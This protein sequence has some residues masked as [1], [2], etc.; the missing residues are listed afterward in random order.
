MN[1]LDP[2]PDERSLFTAMREQ[3]QATPMPAGARRGLATRRLAA[4]PRVALGGIA[5]TACG[6]VA[7]AAGLGAFAGTAPA[8]AVTDNPDGSVTITLND[9]NA[10]GAL[11]AKLAAESVAVRAVPVE[12]GCT[13]RASVVKNGVAGAPQILDAHPLVLLGATPPTGSGGGLISLTVDPPTAPGR[14]LLVA[15][16]GSGRMVYSEEIQGPVPACVGEAGES[17]Q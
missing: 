9:L 10:I 13:A 12:P 14:T 15:A 5:A 16:S 3:I 4:R 17:A 7:L 2:Q 8:F 6:A 1:T 11:D